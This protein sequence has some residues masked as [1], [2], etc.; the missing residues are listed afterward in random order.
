M[1]AEILCVGTELLLGEIV[2][3]NA[4]F[5]AREL[6]ALG[7]GCYYQTVVGDNPDRLRAALQTALS[8]ADVV[9]TTGGLGPTG[10]DLTKE[11]VAEYFGR[12]LRP[13]AASQDNIRRIFAASNRP[14]T[15]NNWKQALMPAGAI[16]FHN[17]R[18]TANGLAVEDNGKTVILLPGPPRE[19]TAM[20]T[21]EVAPYLAAK[22][23]QVLVS[24]V[25]NFF[26]IGESQL[27][28]QL[29]D[30]LLD[31]ANPTLALYAGDG[32]VRI[33]VTASAATKDAA[34]AL[35]APVID[36]IRQRFPK[37]V[38]GIDAQNL[39]T[40]V[41]KQLAAV[42]KTV[43]VAESCTGGLIASR[44]TSVPGSSDVFGYGVV[45]Y[46]NDAKEQILGVSSATLAEFGAVSSQTA[47]EMAEGVRKLSGADIGVA[48]TGIAGPNG[49]TPEKPVGL[50]WLGI[51]SARGTRTK[52]LRLSRAYGEERNFIRHL[53]A[54]HA[55][56]EVLEELHNL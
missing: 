20:F 26:G 24:H 6:A 1:Q 34:E 53:A 33:R 54:S 28:T 50:V 51:S 44:I 30:G 41:V 29:P 42:G 55:L 17:D 38:Y 19:M 3:T 27:E 32:E 56:S 12:E 40:A 23:R 8:R 13:D 4:A 15:E 11:I 14:I 22:S 5:L 49:G 18:G 2:N 9:I 16:V 48:T 21:N 52:E 35:L 36:G 45:T 10:D 37:K 25:I 43:A 7:I 31:S 39:E 46:A 47:A